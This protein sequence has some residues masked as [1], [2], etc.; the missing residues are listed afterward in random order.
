MIRV[1]S[2]IHY[3]SFGG[4]HNQVLR[5]AQPLRARGF[6]T[7]AVVPDEPGNA[8]ERLETAGIDVMRMRLGRLRESLDW[9]VQRDSM[10]TLV[11]DVPRLTGLIRR[12]R[13]DL[14]V[15]HGSLNLQA[16]L[17]A[18]RCG[19]PAVVQVL[20]TRTP[21]VL[22]IVGAPILRAL[23]TAI[24]TTGRA[25]AD[26][27]PWLPRS[28]SRLFPFF[29]PVDTQLFSPDET[30]RRATRAELGFAPGDVVVGCVA[31]LTPQKNLERFVDVA[32]RLSA[33]RPALR[34]ALFGGRM[35]TH[36]DYAERVLSRAARLLSERSLVVKDVGADVAH[37]VRALDVFLGTA[38]PRS[39]GISTT[40]LEAMST[41]VPV[42]STDVGGIREAVLHGTTG[43]LASASDI[44]ALVQYVTRLAADP[45]E[46][47][48]MARASRDRAVREFD[49]ERC[50]DVH[51]RAFEAALAR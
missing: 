15:V 38:G 20:D 5:L 3:P 12:E 44:D 25:V 30:E 49:V 2:V 50:A 13:I 48:S 22:R 27:H 40:I 36:E 24:M 47:E 28:P 45:V 32:E 19:R 35:K 31:N 37:H 23:A 26:A 9:R 18:R 43:Y 21:R 29:P 42:V 39:E 17:A 41:A 14:V 33:T 7:L 10:R 34:F 46:R 51:A 1:L 6:A 11:G 8:F 16:A 4:P